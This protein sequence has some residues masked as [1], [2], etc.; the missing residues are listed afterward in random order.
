MQGGEEGEEDGECESQYTIRIALQAVI[1]PTIE[2][3]HLCRAMDASLTFMLIF[4]YLCMIS[5]SVMM[6][7]VKEAS[8]FSITESSRLDSTY[9]HVSNRIVILLEC[10]CVPLICI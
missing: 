7:G 5:C 1:I 2:L 9:Y 6:W 3:I 8:A 10:R 4:Q